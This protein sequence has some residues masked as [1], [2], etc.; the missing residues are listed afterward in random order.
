MFEKD[1]FFNRLIC[2]FVDF[3]RNGAEQTVL[4]R[5][6]VPPEKQHV[7]INTNTYKNSNEIFTVNFQ[8]FFFLTTL[9]TSFFSIQFTKSKKNSLPLSLALL[10]CSLHSEPNRKTVA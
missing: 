2:F 6:S 9:L 8:P 7:I 10:F 3:H 4:L 5:N 1:F